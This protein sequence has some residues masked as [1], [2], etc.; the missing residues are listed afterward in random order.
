MRRIA[1]GL[2]LLASACSGGGDGG[3]GFVAESE[4]ND[5]QETGTEVPAPGSASFT[6]ACEG[7]G[8]DWFR[9]DPVAHVDLTIE[10]DPSDAVVTSFD[11]FFD[12]NVTIEGM[13][14]MH[15]EAAIDPPGTFAFGLSCG[16]A[17]GYAYSGSLITE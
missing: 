4:P 9:T 14:G 16:T 10:L 6:G 12:G 3:G 1:F 7:A 2:L 13:D 17:G 15:L 8:S 5:T 11:L